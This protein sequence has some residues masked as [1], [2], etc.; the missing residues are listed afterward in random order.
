MLCVHPQYCW[1]F[2]KHSFYAVV[3]SHGALCLL[4]H[5]DCIPM[6]IIWSAKASAHGHSE[7]MSMHAGKHMHCL[8]LFNVCKPCNRALWVKAQTCS[9]KDLHST[10]P[11]LQCVAA[12]DP[13]ELKT[14]AVT[15]SI[16][17][18]SW[19]YSATNSVS[20]YITLSNCKFWALG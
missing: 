7:S 10:V 2:C 17:A 8:S 13:S 5:V 15:A 1:Y 19:C 11:I 14:L 16:L 18:L 12:R 20:W 9:A 4:M 6:D 3:W